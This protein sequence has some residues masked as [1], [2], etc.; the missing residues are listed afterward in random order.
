MNYLRIL[1]YIL[2]LS[3]S[4]FFGVNLQAKHLIG[5]NLTYKCLG[6]GDYSFTLK[7][8]RDCNCTD[9]AQLDDIAEIGIYRCNGDADCGR[10]RQ[11]S[12]FS[13]VQV[14]LTSK[15]NVERPDYPCLIPPNI[16]VEEGI[17]EFK[18]SN[19]GIRLPPG[20]VSYHVSYQ[21]CCRNNT[22]TNI[23]NP[24]QVG[25]T[26]GIEITP[27]AQAV[28][29]NSPEFKTF[30][31]TV[32]CV[33]NEL[34]YDHSAKDADGDS[35][36]YSFC[37]PF[38]GGGPSTNNV[39]YRTCEGAYPTPACPPPYSLVTFRGGNIT[40]STPMA[41]DPIVSIDSKTGLI[42]GKPTAKGQFVVGVCIA[43]YRNGILISKSNR[44]FQFNVADCDPLVFAKL[45]EAI[46]VTDQEYKVISCGITDVKF[47]NNSY[48]RAS[49][50]SQRWEFNVGNN[51]ITSTDWEPTLKFPGIGKYNGK[52]LLNPGTGCADSAD[53]EV[54]IFPDLTADFTYNYDTC[55][56]QP[57]NFTDLSV[58]GSGG[59]SSYNWV[60]GDGQK[61]TGKLTGHQ[62]NL[63]G[64]FSV[65]L[66]VKDLNQCTET[67]TK[68]VRY[69]PAPALLVVKPS[70]AVGCAP[71]N[72]VFDNL[73]KP[74]DESYKVNWE[75]G[76]GG[77]STKL[78]PTYT[79][80]K[81]GI[82]S[83]SLSVVSP[84]GCKIDTVFNN[85]IKIS[86]SPEA[87]FDFAPKQI[88]NIDNKVV[89]TDESINAVRWR[90]DFGDN[91]QLEER[92]PIHLYQD[93]GIFTITLVV[94]HPSG[95]LDTAQALL[96]VRPD[97]RYFLPNAFTPNYDGKNDIFRG[98]GIMTGATNFK[99]Q[100]W[101]RWGERVFSTDDIKEGW[102]GNHLN[103]GSAS[104]EGVYITLISYKDPRGVP[105]EIKGIVTLLR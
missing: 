96:D 22:I 13:R 84:I 51:K 1:P 89:F 30:P 43:E 95:C 27:E 47:V 4:C 66:T 100:I 37:A 17:Y 26:Y 6:N 57:V 40:S 105:V 19:Y 36:V 91:A 79:Y 38:N 63:A 50:K 23:I 69:F 5:G 58:S 14:R 8:Y 83:V 52:L 21:R 42:T 68:K 67:V 59:I 41:G 18:L 62:Y 88:T 7:V 93:T 32:I 20:N 94:T 35:L 24:D 45:G 80:T 103:N 2:L 15:R 104:P 97:V 29:N 98:V 86:S 60:F 49:I 39:I 99:F 78:N 48:Q 73:S 44:D 28:C 61:G 9:C 34:K 10:L 11:N 71:V 31:P 65:S 54:L 82:Y 55:Y 76:D 53:I 70:Q 64:E 56:A 87:A 25:S 81:E 101:N 46:A 16:C 90:W 85:L 77:K 92:N 72:M 33:N 102:N 3:I 12:V 74:I 75:F